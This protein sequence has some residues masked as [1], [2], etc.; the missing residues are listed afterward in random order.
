MFLFEGVESHHIPTS[1]LD[2]SGSGLDFQNKMKNRKDLPSPEEIDRYVGL[3][4]ARIKNE[5][6][7]KDK[8]ALIRKALE[9]SSAQDTLDIEELED[10]PTAVVYEG[11]NENIS[12][13]GLS[14]T[15]VKRVH[16]M[17]SER[18]YTRLATDKDLSSLGLKNLFVREESKYEDSPHLSR[19]SNLNTGEAHILRKDRMS[20]VGELT[21]NEEN[22]KTH[23][24]ALKRYISLPEN[25]YLLPY[26]KYSPEDQKGLVKKIS[27]VY[28]F[29]YCPIFFTSSTRNIQCS[30]SSLRPVD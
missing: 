12:T 9:S 30:R 25:E 3:L 22:A 27:S 8:I 11:E 19:I 16:Q 29:F 4:I 2:I 24:E 21:K 6:L 5:R 26:T 10:Q 20:E 18:L 23:A 14:Y 1:M 15:D 17:V 13:A 7:K 28:W